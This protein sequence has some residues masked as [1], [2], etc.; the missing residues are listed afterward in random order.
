MRKKT[1]NR[2][3]PPF[4][5]PRSPT[6][7]NDT[8]PSSADLRINKNQREENDVKTTAE[9]SVACCHTCWICEVP[10][11]PSY[12]EIYRS[13]RSNPPSSSCLY[14]C[15]PHPFLA[16]LSTSSSLGCSAV[17]GSSSSCV[18]AVCA[19]RVLSLEQDILSLTEEKSESDGCSLCGKRIQ[20]QDNEEEE[21]EHQQEGEEDDLY[22]R[23]LTEK[24]M[25]AYF[26]DEEEEET[27]LMLCDTCPR[28]FCVKCW[29]RY[30]PTFQD[31]SEP[32][33][34]PMCCDSG[35]E[36][37]P[38]E[39]KPKAASP[40]ELLDVNT[41]SYLLEAYEVELIEVENHRTIIH[42]VH[43]RE[44][45]FQELLMASSKESFKNVDTGKINWEAQQDL[46]FYRK[47]WEH[48]AI[49]LQVEVPV[50]QELLE[51]AGGSLQEFY[52][53]FQRVKESLYPEERKPF[54]S[55]ASEK[56]ANS[57]ASLSLKA[58]DPTINNLHNGNHAVSS[59]IGA[60]GYK[61]RNE[62]IYELDL[63][64]SSSE[65]E[66]EIDDDRY[67][68]EDIQSLSDALDATNNMKI[69]PCWREH[70]SPPKENMFRKALK[71]E[72][73][74]QQKKAFTKYNHNDDSASDEMDRM[75]MVVRRQCL[76]D[77]DGGVEEEDG[78]PALVLQ[79]RQCKERRLLAI[80]KQSTSTRHNLKSLK[81]KR[82]TASDQQDRDD[83]VTIEQKGKIKRCKNRTTI[84]TTTSF[85]PSSSRPLD[86][87]ETGNQ[88]S[89]RDDPKCSSSLNRF[90]ESEFCLYDPDSNIIDASHSFNHNNRPALQSLLKQKVTVSEPLAKQLKD[91]QKEGIQFMWCVN[92]IFELLYFALYHLSSSHLLLFF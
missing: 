60:S 48:H 44:E 24:E 89:A 10:L 43:K 82:I 36:I 37:Q 91:H 15:Y 41:L 25:G 78:E 2:V 64:P 90:L 55:N 14:K 56:K 39:E 8:T 72:D 63:Y 73:S 80:H 30:K 47:L 6:S 32:L 75:R 49:R 45:I 67:L 68:I 3:C 58:R 61:A 85:T 21:G 12:E 16:F 51:I 5:E 35:S 71:E 66:E 11:L 69:H 29:K 70:R 28:S 57:E 4:S 27:L 38:R 42:L 84:I 23:Q 18:C 13:L 17:K 81:R 19:D 26:E 74:R 54:W 87:V 7:S 31:V 62:R 34:C 65:D 9:A 77:E 83:S 76:E 59:F 79:V 86:Y 52:E 20:Q 40:A 53:E 88:N 33:Q 92:I 50:L 22:K 46:I 1:T